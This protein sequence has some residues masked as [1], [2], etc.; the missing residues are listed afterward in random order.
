MGAGGS[1]GTQHKGQEKWETA[2]RTLKAILTSR[3]KISPTNRSQ[4]RD[5]LDLITQVREIRVIPGKELLVPA[6][7]ERDLAVR[8]RTTLPSANANVAEP[9]P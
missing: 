8:D 3:G 5:S 6:I 2:L 7:Q 4:D 1:C 9:K